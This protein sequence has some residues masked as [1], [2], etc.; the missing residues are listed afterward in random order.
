MKDEVQADSRE[1]WEARVRQV[2]KGK[3]FEHLRSL[4]ADGIEIEPL[5]LPSDRPP[6][7]ARAAG[8][9][10]AIMQ[11]VDHPEAAS[12]NGLALADLANGA[13]GLVLTFEGAPSARGFGLRDHGGRRI[14]LALRDVA[15]HAID[16]RLEAG[17]HGIE[18]AEAMRE[19][20]AA[21]SIAPDRARVRFGIDPIGTAAATGSMG[22]R[23]GDFA[24]A[25]ARL[26]EE[27]NG[28]IVEADGRPYHD[29]G[30]SEA[31]ELGSALATAVSYLRALEDR[32]DERRVARA[33]GMTLAADADIFLTMAK[34]RAAR[35]LWAQVLAACGAAR[36]PLSL[37]GEAS[38]RMMTRHDPHVNI[39]RNVAAA[40]AAGLGGANSFCALPFSLAAGLPDGFARRVARNM[41]SIVME[42]AGLHH[43]ADPAAGSGYLDFLT[44]ALAERAWRFFQEIER[45]GGMRAALES[46]YVQGAVAEKADRRREEIAEGKRRIIGV[47]AF[48]DF[49]ETQGSILP[50][51]PAASLERDDSIKAIPVR[52]DAEAAETVRSEAAR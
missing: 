51:A 43:V 10:W 36:E 17:R 47:N 25:A 6:L 1:P 15:L 23:A 3:P 35:L 32:I 12:A 13:T 20:I 34:F 40:T 22:A 21:R 45:R 2:L 24:A 9:R 50:V 5:Y 7:E 14:G 41:Q 26:A 16:I 29:G 19:V 39:L 44:E 31:Q 33:V 8:A 27:F 37:H 18:A 28:P 38:W 42:E 52:R 11:R 30:G 48:A 46:G 4:T 49:R